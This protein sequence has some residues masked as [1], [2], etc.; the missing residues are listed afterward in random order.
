MGDLLISVGGLIT[1]IINDDNYSIPKHLCTYHPLAKMRMIDHMA[2]DMSD[3][4]DMEKARKL[5]EQKRD[6]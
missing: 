6:D 5:A 3:S 1:F 2:R 4:I